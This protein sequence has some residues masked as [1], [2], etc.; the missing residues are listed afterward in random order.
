[1]TKLT[2]TPRAE[3]AV[4]NSGEWMIDDGVD[5]RLHVEGTRN[6]YITWYA[7]FGQQNAENHSRLEEELSNIMHAAQQA[8]VQQAYSTVLEIA[9]CL[10]SS[11]GQFLD[12]RGY[13][14]DGLK[15][16]TQAVGA[17][18]FLEDKSQEERLLGKLGRAEMALRSWPD[19]TEN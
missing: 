19:A 2:V 10:W 9:E 8:M 14:Q 12:L 5:W 17:A 3:A 4:K 18:R 7:T 6:K 11:G 16:L 1:M 13:F 15:L